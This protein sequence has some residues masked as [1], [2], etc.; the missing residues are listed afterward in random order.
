MNAPLPQNATSPQSLIALPESWIN[1][2]FGR[3]EG[4]YGSRFHDL[5]KGTDLENVKAVW[6]EK[7]AGIRGQPE[8]LKAAL[9][10]C[11]DKPWPP[12]LPEFLELCRNAARRAQP[13][14]AALPPP[15]P[16]DRDTASKR[17]AELGIGKSRY[18]A[19][20]LGWAKILREKYLSGERLIPIQISMASE[21]L[22]EKWA[23]GK[24]EAE[25]VA[26]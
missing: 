7:L 17:A 4:L 5:W 10:A 21:A 3:L 26:A 23:H 20:G 12:T 2:L 11:D 22:G 19:D 13:S 25:E 14:V 24:I 16:L 9:D 15:A 1:R 8:V 6:A 18:P